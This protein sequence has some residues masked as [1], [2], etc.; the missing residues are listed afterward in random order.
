LALA[1]ECCRGCRCQIMVVRVF[2]IGV[3]RIVLAVV[4]GFRLLGDGDRRWR[5]LTRV[6]GRAE[7][8]KVPG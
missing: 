7:A 3:G 1:P 6:R 4:A 8:G 5:W 2:R